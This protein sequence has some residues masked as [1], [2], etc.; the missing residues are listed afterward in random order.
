MGFLQSIRDLFAP[1]TK[2]VTF[3]PTDAGHSGFGGGNLPL[4]NYPY[5]RDVRDGL[6]SNVIMAPVGWILRNFTQ[7]EA[8]VERLTGDTWKATPDHAIKR[9]MVKPNEFYG[10][11]MLWKATLLSY[12]LDGNGYWRKIRNSF[13]EVI[14][15]WYMPHF[16][17]EPKWPADGSV[18]VSHYEYR[19]V[20]SSAAIKLAPRDVVHFRAIALDPRNP[21]LGLGSLRPLLREIST[22][23]QAANFSASILRNMGVPGGLISPKDA[24]SVLKPEDKAEMKQY[25]QTE[26]TGD[27]RGQWMVATIPTEVKQFGFDPASLMLANL[28]DVPEERV[29]ALLGIP[30]AVVGF[31]TGLQQVKVGA[32]MRELREEAWASGIEPHQKELAA[33]L[34][35]SLIPDFQTQERRFRVRFDTSKVAALMERNAEVQGRMV[36]DGI[37]RVDHAQERLGLEVDDS[38]AVYLRDMSTMAVPANQ[39]PPAPVPAQNGRPA[40][41]N[42]IAQQVSD[43]GGEA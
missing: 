2:G 35:D 9:L 39:K 14:Q 38:Q 31:G 34:S 37:Q 11:G 33:Q 24:S 32:T 7:A 17:V 41:V 26:F 27:N 40:P 3:T 19:P 20:G 15:L 10:G 6:D 42:R 12:L 22:D 43:N 18:F 1:E 30:A 28:R 21:R 29:C 5:R 25:M 13:G 36:K 23:E 8:I 4:T 16:M